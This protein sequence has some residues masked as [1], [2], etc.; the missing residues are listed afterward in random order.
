MIQKLQTYFIIVN[1]CVDGY[2]KVLDFCGSNKGKIT[3]QLYNGEIVVTPQFTG[4]LWSAKRTGGRFSKGPITFQAQRQI[5]KPTPVVQQYS[6]Q[7]TIIFKI[8]YA[9]NIK[10]LKVTGTFEKQAP[11]PSAVEVQ[12]CQN[13][14]KVC[15]CHGLNNFK[16]FVVHLRPS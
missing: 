16:S 9:A 14:C 7:L 13:W 1:Q 5:L 12:V 11:A 10:Q 6:S 2:F 3:V 15:V 4:T 8:T